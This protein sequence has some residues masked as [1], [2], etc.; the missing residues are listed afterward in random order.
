[1]SVP[2]EV[3][4]P[5]TVHFPIALL[6]V[7]F[8][9]ETLALAFKFPAWHRVT[10]WNLVLGTWAALVAGITGG[11]AAAVARHPSRESEAVLAHHGLWGTLAFG[12][13]AAVMAWHLAAGQAMGRRSR[14]MAWGLLGLTCGVTAVAAHLG[15]TLVYEHGVVEVDLP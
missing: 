14:W 1:M 4:H 5:M 7:A 11:L 6:C 15:A 8:L 2:I 13:A 9:V 12:L 3:L 10:V